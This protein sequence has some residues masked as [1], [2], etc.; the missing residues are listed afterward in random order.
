MS[1]NFSTYQNKLGLQLN[2]SSSQHTPIQFSFKTVN[3]CNNC[4]KHGHLFH[5]CC[6]PITS[7][8]IIAFTNQSLNT[9]LQYL[10]IR[11]KDGF[12]YIEFIRGKYSLSNMEQIQ[13]I[14]DEM[15]VP[16]KQR[17]LKE[18]FETLR[19]LMW[20]GRNNQYKQEET[21]AQKKFE[22]LKTGIII[23]DEPVSLETLVANSTT[24][25]EE[26]EWE[27]PKGRRNYQEKDIECALR[28]FSEETGCPE[29]AIELIDNLQP[30]EETFIGSNYKAYKHKYYLA[31][32]VQCSANDVQHYQKTEVSK[33]Q[34]K[35]CEECLQDIRPYNLEKKQLITN[36]NAML[37]EYRTY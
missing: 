3:T 5:Q 34:W 15:S 8:G 28:E 2:S 26:T 33:I 7:C 25:W 37:L 10:M 24:A 36:I 32:L 21:M 4:G 13:N 20:G 27:F 35:T 29:T 16:E 12:G 11:R 22:A 23:N 18:P 1:G 6:L 19:N 30:F 31:K 9:G 14:I 17:I